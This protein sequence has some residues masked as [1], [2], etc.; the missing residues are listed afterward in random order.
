MDGA[1]P[2]ATLSRTVLATSFQSVTA[3]ACAVL[4]PRNARAKNTKNTGRGKLWGIDMLSPFLV[5]ETPFKYVSDSKA[6]QFHKTH[7]Q[8]ICLSFSVRAPATRAR[9]SSRVSPLLRRRGGLPRFLPGLIRRRNASPR[10]GFFANRFSQAL[11]GP[12]PAP[13]RRRSAVWARWPLR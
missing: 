13:A 5:T 2:L 1:L 3:S 4:D 6:L 9:D 11:A 7:S 8:A 12:C 10:S